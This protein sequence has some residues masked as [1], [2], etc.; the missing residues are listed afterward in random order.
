MPSYFYTYEDYTIWG[1]TALI[2]NKFTD[3]IR[4]EI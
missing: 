4:N 2:I 3:I 1:F